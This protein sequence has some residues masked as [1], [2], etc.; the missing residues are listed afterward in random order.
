MNPKKRWLKPEVLGKASQTSN[1]DVRRCHQTLALAMCRLVPAIVNLKFYSFACILN[2]LG[3]VPGG[4]TWSIQQTERH[5]V[6]T[7][8]Y[9][10][11]LET[12]AKPLIITQVF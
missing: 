12:I 5:A 9:K 10:L 6:C 1:T 2:T 8:I 4:P 11:S 7:Y 3:H